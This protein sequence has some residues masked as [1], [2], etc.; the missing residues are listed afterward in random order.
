MPEFYRPAETWPAASLARYAALDTA[1]PENQI[2]APLACDSVKVSVN[3]EKIRRV[4]ERL[5]KL[6]A[7]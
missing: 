2:A 4:R 1:K 7:K 3:L 6:D 5:P